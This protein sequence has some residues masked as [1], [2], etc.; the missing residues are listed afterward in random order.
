MD[1]KQ[2]QDL[3]A[4]Q[5]LGDFAPDS[6]EFRGLE[7]HMSRCPACRREYQEIQRTLEFIEQHKAEFA[8]AFEEREANRRRQ[9][10]EFRRKWKKLEG[11]LDDLELQE[12]RASMRK[13]LWRGAAVAA[14]GVLAVSTWSLLSRQSIPHGG[15][16][17]SGGYVTSAATPAVKI[18]LISGDRRVAIL[19]NQEISTGA[20]EIKTLIINDRH[21]MVMN[22][23]TMLAVEPLLH[24][25]HI[26]CR[27]NL[28]A[29]EVFAQVE[30]DGNPF[31]VNTPHGQAI[32][33]GTTFDVKAT[34][35]SSV[36]VVSEG[37]VRFASDR[38]SAN[39][40]A[41]HI[42][43]I[44]SNLGPTI[45]VTCDAEELTAWA[46]QH[47]HESTVTLSEPDLDLGYLPL[48]F[49][50]TE[51]I[52]LEEVDYNGWV[53]ENRDWFR[54]QFPWI[55]Q[56]KEALAEKGINVDYPE[57]LVTTGDIWQFVCLEESL[58]RL[59]RD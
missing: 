49:L 4:P 23:N 19:A 32:I 27:V 39:V 38:G 30:H 1:C 54:Q 28:S 52:A 41:G 51:P 44:G 50:G 6:A 20:G 46:T 45:P 8:H 5:M 35:S 42:S 22:V 57:L 58:A 26:G 25:N 15:R 11:K 48:S 3:M 47:K 36:L 17:R 18:E 34:D 9:D 16:D 55:F 29:G 33:T 12:Q 2:A 56:L 31:V 59:F 40:T 24:A 14:C 13:W 10:A 37:A 7:A 53:E 21:R 43:R